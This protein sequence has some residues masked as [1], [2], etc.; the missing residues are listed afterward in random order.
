MSDFRIGLGKGQEPNKQIL[1]IWVCPA[2]EPKHSFY[3]FCLCAYVH[4]CR[5]CKCACVHLWRPKVDAKSLPDFPP[6][7]MWRPVSC[8]LKLSSFR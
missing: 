8:Y 6:P 7:F 1:S 4:M 5:G 2:T 3:S